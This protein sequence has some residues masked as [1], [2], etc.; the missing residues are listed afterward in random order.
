MSD[1]IPTTVAELEAFQAEQAEV[2]AKSASSVDPKYWEA[3]QKAAQLLG[4][5]I[6]W[7]EFKSKSFQVSASWSTGNPAIAHR[8]T[9]RGQT[10]DAALI[11]LVS[12]L[13]GATASPAAHCPTCTCSPEVLANG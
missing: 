1:N 12:K 4:A 3:A 7:P 8:E 9:G 5:R 11:D 6:D 13:P 2:P 10:A